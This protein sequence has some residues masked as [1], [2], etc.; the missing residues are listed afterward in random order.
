M[1]SP[2]PEPGSLPRYGCLVAGVHS[3][4]GKTTW[5]LLLAM[6]ARQAGWVV[7]PYKTG[8]DYI[9]TGHLSSACA[10]RSCRNLD[11]YL[12]G[13]E[14]IKET[15]YRNSL[16]ADFVLAEGV[17]GLFDGKDILGQSAST[18]EMAKYLGLPVLLVLDGS[19]MAGS[20]AAIVL[21]FKNFDPELKIAGCL[22]NRVNSAGH[23]E[24]IRKAIETKT[25]I[26]CLGYLPANQDLQIPERHLGLVTAFERPLNLTGWDVAARAVRQNFDWDSFSIAVK[27]PENFFEKTAGPEKIADSPAGHSAEI[28]IRI[29]IAKDAAFSFYYQDNLDL[30]AECGAELIPFSPLSDERVPDN[31]DLLYFGGGFPELYAARLS[32]NETMK[33]AVRKHYASGGFIFAECGGLMYLVET[34]TDGGGVLHPMAGLIPGQV[35]MTQGLQNFGYHECVVL[36]D[37]FLWP[38]GY[39]FRSHEFHHSVWDREGEANAFCR[40]G[41]RSEGF[42]SGRLIATYQHIHFGFDPD[43]IKSMIA[44][45]FCGRVAITSKV[46]S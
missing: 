15:F 37:N 2:N 12:L 7:Q 40:I 16:G 1:P 23:Y 39:P 14:K 30:L 38:A 36:K 26:P 4:V 31:T 9:D 32:K 6:M 19:K 18:A 29:G 5:S 8:P 3:S 28:K 17:M 10:P 42:H 13:K 43:P 20:A 46:A 33:A 11:S 44:R 41:S 24:R 34:L 27:L 21:G 45:L 25:G 22:I 35:R